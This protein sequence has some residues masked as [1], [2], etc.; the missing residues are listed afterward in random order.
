MANRRGL[1]GGNSIVYF[2]IT[3]LDFIWNVLKISQIIIMV[4]VR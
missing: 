3:D 1:A 2:N 4:S